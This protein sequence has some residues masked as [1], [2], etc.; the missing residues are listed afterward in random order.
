MEGNRGH[1]GG[2]HGA[3]RQHGAS[4]RGTGVTGV[5]MGGIVG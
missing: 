5:Y 2:A 3:G 4:A 1:M